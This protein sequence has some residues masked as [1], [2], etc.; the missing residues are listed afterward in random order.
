MKRELL[1]NVKVQPYTSGDA[2]DRAGFLSAILGAKVSADGNLTITVTHGDTEEAAE[3][4]TDKLVFPELHT[5]GGVLTLNGVKADDVIDIDIDLLSLK[6]Y[7]K[8]TVSGASAT[9]AIAL[10][11]KNVQ[12]V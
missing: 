1:H 8:F 6:E 4:V 9:L 5:E 2:V 10:G 7:V 3:A 12:S 11:D